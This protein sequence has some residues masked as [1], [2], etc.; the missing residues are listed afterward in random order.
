MNKEKF[1]ELHDVYVSEWNV[2][3]ETGNTS[4]IESRMHPDYYVTFFNGNTDH[5]ITFDRTEAVKG[6]RQSVQDLLNAEKRFEN[7]IVQMRDAE[8]A[9]VFFEQ[10]IKIDDREI[11]RLFT[12]E[13]WRHIDGKWELRREIEELI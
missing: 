1:I 6:M 8:N 9:V 7:R 5:P 3:I 11:S 12:I 10:V 4:A 13:N 2:A